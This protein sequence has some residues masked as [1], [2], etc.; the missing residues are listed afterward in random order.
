[1]RS[2]LL[3]AA[4]GLI[5]VPMLT[6]VPAHAQATRTWVSGVGDDANPCSRTAPC[7]TFP[8]AISK[9]AAGGEINVL[10]PGG[11][12]AV[13][14]TKPISIVN[15]GVG[16]AGVLVSGT[17]GIIVSAGVGDT[18]QLRGLFIDGIGTGLNG[19]RFL[20]G[21]SLYVTNCVIQQFTQFG[22][23]FEPANVSA[24]NTKLF[25]QDTIIQ[26][27][28]SGASSG[29]ILIRPAGSPASAADVSLNRVAVIDNVLGI[30]S[31]GS[32]SGVAAGFTGVHVS[33]RHSV[34]ANNTSNGIWSFRS[35]GNSTVVLVDGTSVTNNGGNGVFADTSGVMLLSNSVVE[36]N[37]QG[38]IGTAANLLFTYQNNVIDN[39]IGADSQ[40]LTNRVLH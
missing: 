8:G 34:V 23:D 35:G 21:R 30:K 2:S 26:N 39:N 7:K 4:L 32:A 11:F 13:T 31:D 14:I 22:I 36:N 27:N 33:V 10:D 1:M 25:V 24:V 17:N 18:I 19:I 5:C 28:G 20:A 6:S 29:G 9:T 16:E 15:E 40:N 37:G 3:L 38:A 12:G